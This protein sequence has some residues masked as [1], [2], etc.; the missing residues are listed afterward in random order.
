MT[1]P[2]IPRPRPAVTDRWLL[3]ASVA[4]SILAP[5]V[6]P[7]LVGAVVFLVWLSVRLVR[8]RPR[9]VA[10]LT[11]AIVLLSLSI[12]VAVAVGAATAATVSDTTDGGVTLTPG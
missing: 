4:V 8:Q 10:L 12:A 3:A 1:A 9:S 5:V 6:W 2:A 7:A 11:T